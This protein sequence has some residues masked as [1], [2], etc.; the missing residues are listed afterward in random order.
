MPVYEYTCPDCAARFDLRRRMSQRDMST[1]CP[2][3]Q[4]VNAARRIS[5]PMVFSHTGNGE[6]QMVG[7]SGS[8]C[9]SCVASTCAGCR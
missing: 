2:K 6:V 7:G 5:M 9:G 4:G 8:A 1:Q 3:C